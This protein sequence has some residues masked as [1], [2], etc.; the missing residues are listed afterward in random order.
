MGRYRWRGFGD[1]LFNVNDPPLSRFDNAYA[2][3]TSG[4]FQEWQL[5]FELSMPI[6]FRLAHVAVRNA[7]LLLARERA[8][9][10]DQQREI[11][12][13]AADAIAEMDRSHAVLQSSFNRLVASRDQLEA[14]EAAY[15]SDKATLDLL[16][17]A[18]RRQAESAVDYTL[19]RARYAVATKNVHFI[20]GTLLDYD[21]VYLAEGPWPGEA[22]HDAAKREAS[23]SVPRP[24]NYASS[25]APVVSM[26]PHEQSHL[27]PGHFP[28]AAPTP[29]IE[30]PLPLGAPAGDRPIEQ[31][32]AAPSDEPEPA[33]ST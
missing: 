20:K 5:G 27:E 16:L 28:H 3:L 17:E 19:S 24:L 23:R 14:V 22:Y 11:V 7:E 29:M 13:E 1:D 31:P 33:P 8:I 15:E 6:G 12:H 18:Q 2:D 25:H 21:G 26:G 30:E 9:L 10:R 4:D 32:A